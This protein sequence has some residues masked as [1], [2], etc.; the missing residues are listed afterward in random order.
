MLQFRCGIYKHAKDNN[1]DSLVKVAVDR[2]M[3]YAT[4]EKKS[5]AE[6]FKLKIDMKGNKQL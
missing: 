3:E 1:D 5:K 2:W 4:P 6:D